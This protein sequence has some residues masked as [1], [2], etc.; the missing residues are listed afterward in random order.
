MLVCFSVVM[1]VC[2]LLFVVMLY[3][4]DVCCVVCDCGCVCV[5]MSVFVFL[6]CG[7][8]IVGDGVI[9]VCCCDVCC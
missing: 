7:G 9:V 5:L 8:V 3:W 2:M 1:C 4:F 6:M